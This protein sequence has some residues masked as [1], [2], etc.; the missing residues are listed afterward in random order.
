MI[1]GLHAM[2]YSA[3]ATELRAFFRDKLRLPFTDVGHGW[4]IFDAPSADLG[5]HPTDA[6]HPTAPH[7]THNISFFCTNIQATVADL[8]SRG[9]EFMQE[10]VDRYGTVD[11]G[12]RDPSGNG[13]K[14]IESAA[15][16]PSREAP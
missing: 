3:H 8:Q 6:A 5:V 12:F 9:V 13:W 2:F 7:N 11:A 16:P 4:L 1:T 15:N 10:P 14:M